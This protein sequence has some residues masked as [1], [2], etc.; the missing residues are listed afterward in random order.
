MKYQYIGVGLGAT[1]LHILVCVKWDFALEWVCFLFLRKHLHY[2]NANIRKWPAKQ[3]WVMTCVSDWAEGYIRAPCAPNYCKSL[4]LDGYI[5][6]VWHRKLLEYNL[7]HVHIKREIKN[8]FILLCTSNRFWWLNWWQTDRATSRSTTPPCS[9][10]S[11]KI[12]EAV[13][14]HLSE[15]HGEGFREVWQWDNS[16]G[17]Q[18]KSVRPNTSWNVVVSWH[19]NLTRSD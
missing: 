14:P 6:M 19:N 12:L 13:W 15:Q 10:S 11:G 7:V 1:Q 4:G 16:E 17:T 5:I 9:S 2:F 3:W 8:G 18:E